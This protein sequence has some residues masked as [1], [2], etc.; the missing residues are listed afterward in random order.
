MNLRSVDLNLLVVLD[1][2]LDEAHVSRA[3]ERVGLSQP[4]A[5]SALERCRHLFG[6]RLLERGRGTM[7]LTPKAQSLQEPIKDL[8]AQM[9]ALIDPPAPDLSTLHQTVRM[10]TADLPPALLA[11]ELHAQLAQAAPGITLALLPWHGAAEALEALARGNADLAVSVFP[12]VEKDFIRKELLQERYVVAMRRGHPAA[13][14]FDLER[15]LAY[16]HILISGRGETFGALD[17]ALAALGR[18]RRIGLVVPS[19]LLVPPLLLGS[20]LIALLPSRTLPPEAGEHFVTFEPPIPVA[21]FPL[22]V[23]WHRR[24]D[25]DPAVQYVARLVETVLGTA[26]SA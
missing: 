22:H 19:F 11:G 3:A 2:L 21:G 16:R 23:A 9:T 26:I 13:E 25:R 7:L 8:L 6:D 18:S 1:A 15:W 4:A 10:V 20:D 5:S 17:E 12:T 14:S 24:N